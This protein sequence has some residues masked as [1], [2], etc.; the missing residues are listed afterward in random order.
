MTDD[1]ARSVSAGEAIA[2]VHGY[3]SAGDNWDRLRIDASGQLKVSAAG[4]GYAGSVLSTVT[5]VGT[6]AVTVV[7][8]PLTNRKSLYVEADAANTGTIY[9]GGSAVVASN[10]AAGGKPLTAGASFSW[11][12]GSA[13]LYAIG[14]AAGQK[15][16]V[17][18]VA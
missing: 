6:S 4:A 7:S 9:V 17:L 18:E 10:A 2:L 1:L 13:L 3:D 5:T 15:L 12:I 16:I 8:S 14:T 11:D